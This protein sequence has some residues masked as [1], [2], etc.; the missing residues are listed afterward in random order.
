MAKMLLL[1]GSA[2][3]NFRLP[4]ETD[5]DGILSALEAGAAA[6]DRVTVLVEMNDD[7]RQRMTVTV[8]PS[9]CRWWAI[10]EFDEQDAI[11]GMVR[12]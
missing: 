5:A 8:N 12:H 6:G 2:Q 10:A 7:P 11:R 1:L 3:D 4:A 9:A